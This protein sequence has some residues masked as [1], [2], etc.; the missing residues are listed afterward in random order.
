MLR[1]ARFKAQLSP[2]NFTIAEDTLDR[3]RTIVHQGS[4]AALTQERIFIELNKA[5]KTP[6]QRS[7]SNTEDIGALAD[8]LPDWATINFGVLDDFEPTE[9]LIRF[10][11]LAA[12]GE[13]E[14]ANDLTFP[15]LASERMG[16]L[17]QTL[18][19]LRAID[20]GTW[21]LDPTVSLTP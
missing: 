5:L 6:S 3:C 1:L 20:R 14:V 10:A 16:G 13:A 8:L 12:E 15:N 19:S 21:A 9:P 11:R 7:F 17:G 4:L 18:E 2:F